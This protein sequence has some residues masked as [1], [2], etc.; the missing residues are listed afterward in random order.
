M[1]APCIPCTSVR[2]D[3]LRLTLPPP[4]NARRGARGWSQLYALYALR[5]YF[6]GSSFWYA[7]PGAVVLVERHVGV[8]VADDD[9]RGRVPVAVDDHELV[10][11]RDREPRPAA[12]V[13]ATELVEAVGVID[14]RRVDLR[15]PRIPG[16][17]RE[18]G[19]RAGGD[20]DGAA[21]VAV[22]IAAEAVL[23]GE[24]GGPVQVLAVRVDG[25][26]RRTPWLRSIRGW[27]SDRPR[28]RSTGSGSSARSSA[29]PAERRRGR[30]RTGRRR[31]CSPR[32]PRPTGSSESYPDAAKR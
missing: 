24:V 29:P 31:T 21:M 7:P 23:R 6:I 3:S 28:R 5:K 13:G 27:P 12:V 18:V 11:V 9:V 15:L 32:S 20:A 19:R 14:V 1:G 16:A 4:C 17:G 26:G 10:A 25:M 2:L 30:R 8:P 22:R